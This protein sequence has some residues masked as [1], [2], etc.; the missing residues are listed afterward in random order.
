MAPAV[1]DE[2]KKADPDS[3]LGTSRRRRKAPPQTSRRRRRKAPPQ[4]SRQR[5]KTPARRGVGPPRAAAR[6]R[7]ATTPWIDLEMNDVDLRD[8]R[9]N[10]RLKQILSDLA[11]QPTAS[12]PA[13]CGGKAETTFRRHVLPTLSDDRHTFHRLPSTSPAHAAM[14]REAKVKAWSVV[15][16]VLDDRERQKGARRTSC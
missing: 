9:L 7:R 1:V 6:R 2:L 8:K 13:A 11:E 3:R 4:A 15:R 12:I 10:Q 16:K 14:A 5:P